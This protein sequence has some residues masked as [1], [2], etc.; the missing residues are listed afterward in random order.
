MSAI[1]VGKKWGHKEY[2]C[3]QATGMQR[4]L[5]RAVHC[6][7]LPR[8]AAWPRELQATVH[9]FIYGDGHRYLRWPIWMLHT[10]YT[11]LTTIRT[12][13]AVG[14]REEEKACG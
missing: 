12:E 8:A 7:C 13:N 5:N 9:G 14:L 3:G 10:N 6:P 4:D 2:K 11:P 1:N